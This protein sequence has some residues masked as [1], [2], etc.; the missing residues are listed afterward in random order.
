MTFRYWFRR[1]CFTPTAKS[2]SDLR[3]R[4]L[5]RATCVLVFT[6]AAA[7]VGAVLA[8][9]SPAAAEDGAHNVDWAAYLG[10]LDSGQYSPLT[11]ITPENVQNLEVAWTYNAGNASADGLSQI[12]TNPLVIDGVVYGASPTLRFFA[13][14]AATGEELWS[15][16]PFEGQFELHGMGVC[17]GL[18]FWRDGDEQRLLVT[19]GPDLYALDPKTGEPIESF[20]EFGKVDLK[21]GLGMDASKHFLAANTPGVVYEDLYI[22]G[23][24]VHENLPSPPG[25]IRAFD[26]RTGEMR[27]IFHTIPKEGELGYDTWP[28]VNHDEMGAA[29]SW[30][31]MSLDK[32]RGIVY[33]P[34]GSAAYDFYGANRTGDNLF[35]NTLLALDG[36][37][38]KRLW[39][40]QVIHHDVWDRDLPAPPNLV[41]INKDG[42]KIDAVAQIT[43]HAYVFMFDRETG[44]PIFE[45]KEVP[46]PTNGLPGE[47]LSPTQP[48]PVKPPQFSRARFEEEDITRRTAEAYAVVK[49]QWEGIRREQFDAP[50][51]EGTLIFPGYDGGGEWGG[52]AVD[53]E[54]GIMYINSSEMPYILTMAQ[55]E[56]ED[57]TR[58]HARA[59][60]T[61]AQACIVCHGRRGEGAVSKGYPPV[62]DVSSTY[63]HQSLTDLI[64]K[65]KGQMPSFEYLGND[66]IDQLVTYLMEN[67][68]T[69]F[70]PK[71][72]G[73]R[74]GE[75]PADNT[76]WVSTGYHRFF[77]PDGFP[78][79]TPPWGTLNAID[80]NKGEIVWKVTLGDHLSGRRLEEPPTGAENYGGPVVTAGGVIFIGATNDEMFRAF[81][82]K[83]GELL[84]ETELPAG[85]YATPAVYSVDG[86]QYVL[87]AAGGGKMGTKSGDAYMA[88]ALKE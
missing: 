3:L 27:W 65:G 50:S 66:K 41:T 6:V 85:G 42:K 69:K 33:I 59:I 5:A 38:G 2:L 62:K 32:E 30:A 29:N 16:D 67:P 4:L 51:P 13:L 37:T 83:T 31:G 43:K 75:V 56:A 40:F 1:C 24:R 49:E 46:V 26:V 70:D 86:K 71:S 74:T 48:L 61:Y 15:F 22:L 35:A 14:D 87:I 45:I 9:S 10:G 7:T 25:H 80:L 64:A 19:A 68:F 55:V 54:T 81:D 21:K 57:S 36:K 79:I 23:A 18:A 84:W 34:T 39:H 73:S 11:Q 88:F 58:E 28:G 20:G 72:E 78:A 82:K 52:A 76:E 63:T 77:D 53:P 44:E 60:R 47:V 17:R 8:A 12:Q